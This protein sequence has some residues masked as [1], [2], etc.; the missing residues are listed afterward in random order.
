M[1]FTVIFAKFQC[2][3]K[4]CHSFAGFAQIVANETAVHVSGRIVRLNC[5]RAREIGFCFLWLSL[6]RMNV[7]SD[8]RQV[9]V[10]RHLWLEA[11]HNR[12]SVIETIQIEKVVRQINRSFGVLRQFLDDFVAQVRSRLIIFR[13]SQITLA[14]AHNL[15]GIV[16]HRV[17][18]GF[19]NPRFGGVEVM[20]FDR[21]IDRGGN[22]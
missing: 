11:L 5:E 3:F 16:N 21:R 1:G 12:I 19:R 4:I 10:L 6:M 18:S 14:L 17:G 2:R 8:Q 13:E 7:T 22:N 20:P 15:R 9:F